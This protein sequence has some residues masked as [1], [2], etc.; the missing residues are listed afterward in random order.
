MNLST[1]TS[2]VKLKH[3]DVI[4]VVVVVDFAVAVVG[5]AAVVSS[6]RDYK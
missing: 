3:F 6:T 5:F 1:L 2:S 4:V